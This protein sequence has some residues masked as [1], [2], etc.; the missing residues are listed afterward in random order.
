MSNNIYHL[1]LNH[2]Y[3]ESYEIERVKGLSN[4]GVKLAFI[5]LQNFP[6]IQFQKTIAKFWISLK[7]F[8]TQT[9]LLCG[10]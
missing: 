4:N 6:R 5:W 9:F 8:E 10:Q 3:V 1:F 7:G 2:V